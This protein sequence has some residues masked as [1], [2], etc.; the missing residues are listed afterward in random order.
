MEDLDQDRSLG[1]AEAADVCD[2]LTMHGYPGYAAW[3][4]GPT[5]EQILPF[6]VHVTSWLGGGAEVLFT[7]FGVPTYRSGDPEGERARSACSTVL[8]EEPTAASY[9]DRSLRALSECGCM[10]AMLWCY[11]DYVS[12]IWQRPPLDIAIHERSFGLWRA[13]ASPKPAVTVVEALAKQRAAPQVLSSERL[14]DSTWI[15]I[16]P[17][18]FYRT[19]GSQLP[20]LYGRYCE[21][22]AS[23]SR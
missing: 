7:E 1:P 23:E 13:D 15:D 6:L 17:H 5:D 4:R 21:A 22:R 16:E 19:A 10:G 8:V 14:K 9:I 12:A 18:E 11:A 20:R 2:F 3:A